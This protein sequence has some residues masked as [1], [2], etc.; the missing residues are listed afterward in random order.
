MIMSTCSISAA[1]VAPRPVAIC[2][3]SSGSPHSRSAFGH[4]Q[5]RQRRDLRRLED[6]AVAGHQRR[7][8]VAERVRQR[9][10]PRPDHAD[11][12]ER[13]V[14]QDQLL[15]LDEHL[16]GLDRLVGEVVRPLLGP[17]AER[18]AG[19]ADL[20]QARRPRRSCR[21]PRRSSRSRAVALSISHFCARESTRA[22]PSK[23]Y[24]SH[25]G[26]AARPRAA[27]SATAS[28]SRSG[29]VRDGLA[30]GRVL[31]GDP[32]RRRRL[33]HLLSVACW[34]SPSDLRIS[35]S[36]CCS[37][38]AICCTLPCSLVPLAGV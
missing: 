32:A 11:Q 2:R 24:A 17:E 16:A 14:A 29:T 1:P 28:A 19:V 22:R 36:T 12:P 38:L 25:C 21:S 7:D 8:A 27:I 3:T 10:V 20:G 30:G 15:A 13:A 35:C 9:V 26:C 6:H 23:P 34:A 5:R 37:T 18:V 33:D 31:D 4:Q